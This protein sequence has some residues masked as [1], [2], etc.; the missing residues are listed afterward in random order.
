MS[1][2]LEAVDAAGPV[3]GAHCPTVVAESEETR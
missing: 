1:G 2:C 3:A